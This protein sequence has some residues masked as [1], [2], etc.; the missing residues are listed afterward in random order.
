VTAQRLLTNRWRSDAREAG[1]DP[2]HDGNTFSFYYRSRLNV[3]L[4]GGTRFACENLRQGCPGLVTDDRRPA[5][6]SYL[7]IDAS[8]DGG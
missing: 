8:P 5:D 3:R 7:A 1:I 6:Y 2:N 4:A